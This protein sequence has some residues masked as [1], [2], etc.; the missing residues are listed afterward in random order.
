M[1]IMLSIRKEEERGYLS[2]AGH[3]GLKHRRAF[4]FALLCFIVCTVSFACI[5][6]AAAADDD[7]VLKPSGIRYPGGYDL[8][9]VGQVQ[10]TAY[11]YEQPK[12]GPVRFSLRS[13]KEEYRVILSPHWYWSDFNADMAEGEKVKVIGSKSLGKDSNLY[14]IAR[15]IHIVATG[16]S[17]V[18]R[19]KNGRPL[20]RGIGRG[21]GVGHG[22]ISSPAGGRRGT[23]KGKAGRRR[24]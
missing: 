17:L 4:L 11:G 7:T 12:E 1:M 14:I 10:G 22:V 19:N 16:K 24:K 3:A 23:G 13:A 5:S 2:V 21:P 15:E 18:L 8:N 6:P 9:T 20:W